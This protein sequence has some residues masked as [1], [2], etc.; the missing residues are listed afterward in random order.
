M[1]DTS[2]NKVHRKLGARMVEFAGW[3]MPVLYTGVIAEHHAVRKSCG[4]FDVSHMGEIEIQGPEAT[5]ILQKLT[6]NDVSSLIPGRCHYSAFLTDQGTFID[7]IIVNKISDSHYLICVNASNADKDYAHAAPHATPVTS[8][9]NTSASY[10]QIALQGPRS[11]EILRAADPTA[12]RPQKYY[13][14]VPT[15]LMG[16]S[17]L[18]ARTGYTGEDGFEIYGPPDHAVSVWTALM[19]KGASPCGLGA[20]DTLRLEAAMPLYGHEIDDRTTPAEAGLDWIVKME[21]GDFIGRE[22][23]LAQKGLPLRRKLVGIAMR[24]PG[25]AR[26]G[27]RIFSGE[28]EV[29]LIT[30]GTKSPTLDRAIAMGS[31]A[32]DFS[33]VGTKFWIDIHNK[34]REAEVVPLPFY[35]NQSRNKNKAR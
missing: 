23:L 29:G 35:T 3:D 11:E 27:C 31:V 25:I 20:R 12:E 34:K 26:Q 19:E 13:S 18:I 4:I 5:S 9:R 32:L 16:S 22:A 10:Y 33:P 2:L 15:R 17:V 28:S 7:D 6:C 21:K 30:S 1:K 24:E 14:F 8:I